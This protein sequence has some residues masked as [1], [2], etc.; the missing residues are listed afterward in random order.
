M[1]KQD[2]NIKMDLGE[3]GF[4]DLHWIHTVQD[5][6]PWRVFVNTIINVPVP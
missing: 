4:G 5:R 2:D 1:R 6:K 3:R